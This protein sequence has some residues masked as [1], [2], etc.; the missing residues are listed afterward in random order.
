MR[1]WH[2]GW[3]GEPGLEPIHSLQAAHRLARQRW[4]EYPPGSA[5]LR[6]YEQ[7]EWGDLR[8]HTTIYR[9]GE[10]D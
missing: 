5:V 10:E 2:I 8:L 7:D 4:R 6:V 3:V 1:R 9:P